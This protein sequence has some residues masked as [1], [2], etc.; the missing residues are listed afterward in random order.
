MSG[1]VVRAVVRL[2][3][4]RSRR[5]LLVGGGVALAGVVAVLLLDGSAAMMAAFVVGIA[6]FVSTMLAPIGTLV[7]EKLL[8]TLELDRT[9]PVPARTM[10]AARLIAAAVRTLPMML[11]L[12]VIAVLVARETP[13]FPATTLGFTVLATQLLYWSGLWIGYGLLARFNFKK[14]IWLPGV[15][16]LVVVFLPDAAGDFLEQRL[17]EPLLR[18]L[19]EAITDPSRLPALG[20]AVL[21]IAALCFSIAMVLVASGLRRFQADPLALQGVMEKVPREELVPVGRGPVI[22][23]FRLRLR[24]V[25]PQMR[26]EMIFVAVMV[27]ILL[28]EALGVMSVSVLA[29]LSRTYLPVLAFLMPGAIGIQMILNKQLGTVEGLQQLPQRHRDIAIGHLL[30]VLALAVP[31]VV[32]WSVSR[33]FEGDAPSAERLL[34]MW[35]SISAGAWLMAA[36]VLWATLRRVIIAAVVVI[37]VPLV[38]YFGGGWLLPLI[39]VDADAPLVALTR[40]WAEHRDW[41]GP[42]LNF[43]LAAIATAVGLA[44]FTHGLRTYQPKA[45]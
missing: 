15:L 8:G 14:L 19:T 39:G 28:A 11:L 43:V 7:Q 29:E 32:I 22:A 27:A 9:L 37:G 24:I 12:A 26:R 1:R 30:A 13:M 41:L 38:L 33:A 5:L 25:E 35:A 20:L 42:T 44:L 16:W 34:R 3:L 31:A 40:Y 36:L 18:L 21:G 6:L 4:I 45:R 2:E 17:L 23:V 10:A